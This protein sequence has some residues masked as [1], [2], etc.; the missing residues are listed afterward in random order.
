MRVFRIIF[1]HP[2]STTQKA[3]KFRFFSSKMVCIFC[4]IATGETPSEKIYEDAKFIA[5]LDIRPGTEGQTLVIPKKHYGS[6]VFDMPEK[7]YIEILKVARKVGK[8]LDK[9]L[10]ADRTCLVL[11]GLE[12]DHAHVRCILT[13]KIAL[14]PFCQ[15]PG[16]RLQS[17]SSRQGKRLGQI[18]ERFF[19]AAIAGST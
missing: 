4:K 17:C 10:G 5:F 9:A 2:E 7:D 8:Q 12:I 16:K 11:E 19:E 18:C 6:Y 1:S 14:S 13:T 15:T 3:F